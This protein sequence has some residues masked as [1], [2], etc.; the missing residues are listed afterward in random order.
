MSPPCGR[1]SQRIWQEAVFISVAVG[2]LLSG[3][4]FARLF[5]VLLSRLL[6]RGE[7]RG[8]GHHQEPIMLRYDAYLTRKSKGT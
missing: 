2:P 1:Q 8:I 7:L 3:L 4:L 6:A 5:R